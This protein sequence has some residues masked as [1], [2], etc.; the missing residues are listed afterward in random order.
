MDEKQLE[1][2]LHRF[3]DGYLRGVG[4]ARV[5]GNNAFDVLDQ[6]VE[7]KEIP[8][9]SFKHGFEYVIDDQSICRLEIKHKL[10]VFC[11]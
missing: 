4:D 7:G 8:G 5:T 11:L 3:K 6:Y 2:A 9:L 10:P 1:T